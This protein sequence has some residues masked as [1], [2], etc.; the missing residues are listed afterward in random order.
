MT[1]PDA[2]SAYELCSHVLAA[3]AWDAAALIEL[4]GGRGRE[5]NWL[6]C[7]AACELSPADAAKGESAEEC[8][9]KVAKAIIALANTHGGCLL[10]GVEDKMGKA[11]GL[12]PSDRAGKIKKE[13]MD[14][15]LLHLDQ[16]V[17]R[18]VS[19]W[20]LKKDGRIEI[21]GGAPR[22]LVETHS[23]K[24]DGVNILAVLVMPL[25]AGSNCLHC[26][27][28]HQDKPRSILF[29]RKLG[30]VGGVDEITKIPAINEWEKKRQPSSGGYAEL[31]RTFEE[32]RSNNLHYGGEPRGLEDRIAAYRAHLGTKLRYLERGFTSLDAEERIDL[33][34]G[35]ESYQPWAEEQLE[36]D[37]DFDED[38]AAT[39]NEDYSEDED[40]LIARRGSV[41][42]LLAQERRAI[43]L[44]DP[45]AGK[46]TCLRRLALRHASAYETG[47]SVAIYVP[48]SRY[49]RS[50]D[51]MPLLVRSTQFKGAALTEADL[52]WLIQ[53]G[54][55]LLLLD[56]FNECSD[57]LR[58]D[59]GAEIENLLRDHPDL[60]AVLSA[61]SIGW[62]QRVRLPAFT[63][64]PMNQGQ[65]KEFLYKFLGDDTQ[66]SAFLN[67]L[68]SWG[69]QRMDLG[70][71]MLLGMAADIFRKD[72]YLPAG[73]A[74]LYLRLAD[75]W[76]VRER[77]KARAAGKPLPWEHPAAMA[78]LAALAFAGRARGERILPRSDAVKILAVEIDDP[79]KF[80]DTL[81]QG[82]LLR[83]T[84]EGVEFSHES[85]QE[86][87]AAEHCRTHPEAIAF[88]RPLCKA[89]WGMVLV[90]A[91]QLGPLATELGDAVWE[92][93]LWLGA[94]LAPRDKLPVM[95]EA[96]ILFWADEEMDALRFIAT[97]HPE[98]SFYPAGRWQYRYSSNDDILRTAVQSIHSAR[99]RWLA[100]ESRVRP[101]TQQS[102]FSMICLLR[103]M[104]TVQ[105]RHQGFHVPGSIPDGDKPTILKDCIRRAAPIDASLMIAFRLCPTHDFEPRKREWIAKASPGE[106]ALL[107]K[108]GIC[109][110]E[111]F[112]P[113]RVKWVAEASP[114]HAAQLA[115][116]G[117]C[118]VEEF[119]PRRAKWVAEASP[120]EAARWV[121]AGI[122]TA[123]DFQPRRAEWTAKA[124]L[125]QA[126]SLAEAGICM[127]QNTKSFE[128]EWF[129]CWK[130]ALIQ[131]GIMTPEDLGITGLTSACAEDAP[132]SNI[133]PILTA[134]GPVLQNSPSQSAPNKDLANL[135]TASLPSR[136]TLADPKLR[137][138]IEK[139]LQKRIFTGIV[140]D[141]PT[142]VFS[143]VQTASIPD[144]VFCHCSVW[145]KDASLMVPGR[146]VE[147]RAGL[148]FD[149]KK[150]EWS[151]VV[152]ELRISD[153]GP[154]PAPPSLQPAQD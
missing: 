58:A 146:R 80:L 13:G 1:P 5:T 115:E 96:E 131:T 16:K 103:Q 83:S 121:K 12:E 151:Y 117:I 62:S 118:T 152:T 45:G 38:G 95:A 56:A 2:I 99:K 25:P 145:P 79:E 20:P 150:S 29:V 53:S 33:E 47:G 98:R 138:E 60:A 22:D 105:Q 149:Q 51:L 133:H 57:S 116:A 92:M 72:S 106:A 21:D 86:Y 85:Y 125:E 111:E 48:L 144:S 70:I 26:T 140:I 41:F 64:Q 32:S 127:S 93:D 147:F 114:Q 94:A 148:R 109:N 76:Y 31:L 97:G 9:W 49:Q 129:G 18:P 101:R 143:F 82:F 81:G 67:H 78:A 153:A 154:L 3:S 36:P 63:L 17:F 142:P 50:A 102:V 130:A 66:A 110:M 37:F 135:A 44:G 34:V 90:Q 7:K 74:L 136:L 119:Q 107:V 35:I 6:E 124:S 10:L 123:E 42:E 69:Q 15:F 28:T 59:C 40:I 24:L 126:A 84:E 113:R 30:D 54:R 88:H 120:H 68:R 65:R 141:T 91:A 139:S 52:L 43:L 19:G 71:P 104:I 46:T 27:E 132:L 23:C 134:K 55:L 100:Y 39:E 75:L 14:A 128:I 77:T 87:F 73:Q 122:C 89:T 11:V 4:A 112:Q 108:A 137:A 61:R 8:R